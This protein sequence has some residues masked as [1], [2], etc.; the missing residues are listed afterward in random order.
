M[1]QFRTELKSH[2]VKAADLII[3]DFVTHP[4]IP[5]RVLNVRAKNDLTNR[6]FVGTADGLDPYVEG[7]VS[8]DDLTPTTIMARL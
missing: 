8:A 7:E 6:A 1:E 3:G 5:G 4:L 2:K